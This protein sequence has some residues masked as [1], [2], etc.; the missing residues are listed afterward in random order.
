V[1]VSWLT[2]LSFPIFK[3]LMF[4]VV[5]LQASAAR[6]SRPEASAKLNLFVRIGVPSLFRKILVIA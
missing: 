1:P 3:L 2:S 6:A 4:A 5:A